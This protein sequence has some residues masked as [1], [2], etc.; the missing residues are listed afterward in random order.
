MTG[1]GG[2]GQTFAGNMAGNS[3]DAMGDALS[4]QSRDNG[5]E[6]NIPLNTRFK[7]SLNKRWQ[8]EITNH[9]LLS[10][11]FFIYSEVTIG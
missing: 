7:V 3:S 10:P 5:L 11:E 9:N 8:G 2:F 4:Y 1:S 6:L